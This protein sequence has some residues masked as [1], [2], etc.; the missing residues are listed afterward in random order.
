MDKLKIT[1]N[2]DKSIE[3]HFGSWVMGQLAQ[4]G[5]GYDLNNILSHIGDNP[6][7][8]M[9]LL[10][11]LGMCS[12]EKKSISLNERSIDDA[13]DLMDELGKKDN[14]EGDNDILKIR[15]S[16]L[17][18]AFGEKVVTALRNLSEEDLAEK[19]EDNP[20]DKKKVVKLKKK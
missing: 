10:I 15:D 9:A 11:H 13:Y 16:F 5:W 17:I 19:P 7:D 12:A 2:E 20:E 4:K 8:S 14:G 3:L 18:S 6:F 1:V